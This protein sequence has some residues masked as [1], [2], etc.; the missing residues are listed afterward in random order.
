MADLHTRYNVPLDSGPP[1]KITSFKD[2]VVAFYEK[3]NPDG[4][5]K[6]DTIVDAYQGREDELLRTLHERYN[7]PLPDTAEDTVPTPS[8]PKQTFRDT[9]EAFY[10]EHN[11]AGLAKLDTIVDAYAGREDE[12]MRTLHEKYNLPF[13]QAGAQA[14]DEP[15]AASWR[16]KVTAFYVKYNADALDKVDTIL[17]T[18]A[19]REEELMRTLCERYGV[20]YAEEVSPQGDAFRSRVEAFYK[21]HN[22]EGLEKVDA[23]LS[24][25]RGR[26]EELMQ[27]LRERYGVPQPSSGKANGEWQS[28]KERVTAFYEKHNRDFLGRVDEIMARYTGREEELLET[29]HRNYSVPYSPPAAKKTLDAGSSPK[30]VRIVDPAEQNAAPSWDCDSDDE[31]PAVAPKHEISLGRII[32]AQPIKASNQLSAVP[33]TLCPEGSATI[34]E[35]VVLQESD[36]VVYQHEGEHTHGWLAV[37]TDGDT[38]QVRYV[39]ASIQTVGGVRT[40][41]IGGMPVSAAVPSQTRGNTRSF[42]VTATPGG[43]HVSTST[44][45]STDEKSTTTEHRHKDAAVTADLSLCLPSVPYECPTTSESF[46]EQLQIAKEESLAARKSERKLQNDVAALRRR[47]AEITGIIETRAKLADPQATYARE[48]YFELKKV[49]REGKILRARTEDA[50]KVSKLNAQLLDHARAEVAALRDELNASR[51]REAALLKEV[52]TLSSKMRHMTEAAEAERQASATQADDARAHT[53]VLLHLKIDRLERKC[54]QQRLQLWGLAQDVQSARWRGPGP[55]PGSP[56]KRGGVQFCSTEDLEATLSATCPQ[57]A[58]PEGTPQTTHVAVQTNPLPPPPEP[59]VPHDEVSRMQAKFDQEIAELSTTSHDLEATASA[60]KQAIYSSS[61]LYRFVVSFFMRHCPPKTSSALAIV[62]RYW[63]KDSEL[64]R[65]LYA[66]YNVVRNEVPSPKQY[67]LTYYTGILSEIFAKH[68]PE[69]LSDVGRLLD[70]YQGTEEQIVAKLESVYGLDAKRLDCVQRLREEGHPE[71]TDLSQIRDTK[72]WRVAYNTLK[73]HCPWLLCYVDALS[74]KGNISMLHVL[75]ADYGVALQPE[76]L[77]MTSDVATATEPLDSELEESRLQLTAPTTELREVR[78][79]EKKQVTGA[80]QNLVP[81]NEIGKGQPP[82]ACTAALCI[83]A[84]AYLSRSSGGP[85]RRS[86]VAKS[87]KRIASAS[88]ASPGKIKYTSPVASP[89]AYNAALGSL[90]RLKTLN[91]LSKVVGT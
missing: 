51:S 49:E 34:L 89:H 52:T 53:E 18:Y 60:D 70:K 7:V 8:P 68:A 5:S 31:E 87:Q 30:H 66:K 23:I 41:T 86:G 45:S 88:A 15:G 28:Y 72:Q 25:Y 20:S 54:A 80:T 62:Q 75:Q 16:E 71:P 81:R 6:V 29:L 73:K 84:V 65:S 35:R 27:T 24:A 17:Q 14:A 63:G 59:G 37:T 78:T 79:H 3:H 10:K 19:G 82:A 21:V 1:A 64:A 56:S 91:K 36:C 43:T 32:A 90:S 9:V 67:T 2:K 33:L 61:L 74:R 13:P 77:M 11:P 58:F 40:V 47:L 50:D 22:P 39:N 76:D 57:K 48:V 55:G 42:G 38:K 12:L 4:L 26:E 85:A 44:T 69:K 83:A 46:A